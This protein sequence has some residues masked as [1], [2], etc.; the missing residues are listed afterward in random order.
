MDIVGH[1]GDEGGDYSFKERFVGIGA[2]DLGIGDAK[3]IF[4]MK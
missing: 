3:A 2:K 4:K 1:T